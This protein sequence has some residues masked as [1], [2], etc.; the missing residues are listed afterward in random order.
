MK[1]S[2]NTEKGVVIVC[3]GFLSWRNQMLISHVAAGI[4]MEMKCHALRFDFRGNGS[5]GGAWQS[6]GFQNELFDLERVVEFIR[7]DL[8][9]EV[10]CIVGHSKGSAAVLRFAQQQGKNDARITSSTASTASR[11]VPCFV[12]MAGRYTTPG[13]YDITTRFTKEQCN[14][15]KKSGK[16]TMDTFGGKQV[17]VTQQD[18]EERANLDASFVSQISHDLSVLTIHGSADKTVPVDDAYK[19]NEHIPSHTVKIID[20]ADHNFNGLKYTS[21]IVSCIAEFVRSA[22]ETR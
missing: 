5:S 10:E 22:R 13:D 8:G 14:E 19:Y 16:F 20:D 9:C 21:N 12:N 6:A 4:A 17:V 1:S 18:I 2:I 3:H 7:N 11:T 15:L